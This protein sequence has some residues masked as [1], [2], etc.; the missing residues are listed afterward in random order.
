MKRRSC[1]SGDLV[2]VAK[3]GP[4]GMCYLT[5]YA[6]VFFSESFFHVIVQL[7]QLISNQLHIK[8]IITK[9]CLKFNHEIVY[10]LLFY[11]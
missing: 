1:L 5:L 11:M 9:T 8:N 4:C 3:S 7:W 6:F 2:T 10:L